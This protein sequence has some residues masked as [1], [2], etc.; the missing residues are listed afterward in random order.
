MVD[1]KCFL[2]RCMVLLALLPSSTL[3][4]L[5]SD[6]PALIRHHHLE[7]ITNAS[8]PFPAE[9][10][11]GVGICECPREHVC[12]CRM[13]ANVPKLKLNETVRINLFYLPANERL[14]VELYYDTLGLGGRVEP[15]DGFDFCRDVPIHPVPAAVCP[16]MYSSKISHAGANRTLSACIH[17][18]FATDSGT[19]KFVAKAELGCF[20]MKLS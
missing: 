12:E 2:L 9:Q 10:N 7:T 14:K 4:Q 11:K 5:K 16:Q 15:L 17:V 19:Q 8:N 1:K 6:L 13:R 20:L 3:K 18:G